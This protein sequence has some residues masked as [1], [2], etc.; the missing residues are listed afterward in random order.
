MVEGRDSEMPPSDQLLREESAQPSDFV[1]LLQAMGI[2]W[3]SNHHVIFQRMAITTGQH[4]IHYMCITPPLLYDAMIELDFGVDK[5]Q[6]Q[7]II[8]EF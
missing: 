2:S 1:L 7:W 5:H 3:N 8:G 6:Q 4:I